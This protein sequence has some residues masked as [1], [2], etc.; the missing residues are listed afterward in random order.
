MIVL[1]VPKCNRSWIRLFRRDNPFVATGIGNISAP[2]GLPNNRRAIVS[3]G[4][5]DGAKNSGIE[6][7]TNR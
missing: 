2:Q 4:S 3:K 7:S 1:Q 5:P 6:F